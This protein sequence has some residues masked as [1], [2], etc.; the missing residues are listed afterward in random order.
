MTRKLEDRVEFIVRNDLGKPMVVQHI[1]EDFDVAVAKLS[2]QKGEDDQKGPRVRPLGYYYSYRINGRA[3]TADR[4]VVQTGAIVG[5]VV[6]FGDTME[7]RVRTVCNRN[8]DFLSEWAYS[9]LRTIA[10][11]SGA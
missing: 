3:W 10:G 7:F 5:N 9:D 1:L 2:R 4:F 11:H 8:P 6:D